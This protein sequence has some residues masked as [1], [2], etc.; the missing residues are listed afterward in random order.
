MGHLS[1]TMRLSVPLVSAVR[2]FPLINGAIRL[3]SKPRSPGTI[4]KKGTSRWG[5]DA[6][7]G[8]GRA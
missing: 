2:S 8:V 7:E 3:N 6:G 4:Q 1:G 5:L